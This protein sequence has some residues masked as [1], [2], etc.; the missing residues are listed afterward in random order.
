MATRAG[1][2]LIIDSFAGYYGG[3]LSK[4]ATDSSGYYFGKGSQFG[5][6]CIKF[7]IPSISNF[8]K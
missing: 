5:P 7:K 8:F 4:S 6:L 1:S 2:N 3:W